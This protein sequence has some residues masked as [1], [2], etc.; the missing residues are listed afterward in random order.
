MSSICLR[1]INLYKIHGRY[2]LSITLNEGLNVIHGKN[3]AGKSTLIHIIANIVNCDFVRFAYLNFE[4]IEAIYTNGVEVLVTKEKREDDTYVVI[5]VSDGKSIYFSFNDAANALKEMDEER[6]SGD[7]KPSLIH[8]IHSFVK[9]YGLNYTTSSYFPAFRTM[10]E[11][12]GS[13]PES[14]F[15][16]RNYRSVYVQNKI[17][18]FARGLFGKFLPNINYPSP[19]EIEERIKEEIRRAQMGIARYEGRIFSESFVRVFS[20]LINRRTTE[21]SIPQELLS[22]IEGLVKTHD[23]NAK[24]NYYEEYSKIYDEIRLLINRNPRG[25]VESSVAGALTVYRDAL[26]ERQSYQE[27]AFYS[28]DKYF[29]SVNSFLEDKEVCY[30]FDLERRSPRVG[31][32]FPDD[33]WSSIRVMSSGERQLLTMLY[34]ASKMSEDSIV[35]I[36]E[37]EISLHIDWQED[38]LKKMLSQLSGRQ[39]IVCTHSPSIATGYEDCMILINPEFVSSRAKSD[40]CEFDEEDN[41]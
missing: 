23:D 34:A 41:I 27:Q 40:D 22:E 1:G 20:A 32:K 26:R 15:E 10:L 9:T 2:N 21:D 12:W 11:A 39:I 14:G 17:N 6:Y 25:E 31:L 16:R 4:K 33:T 7:T 36:D 3:G 35:L 24:I 37:P 13:Y 28:I 8:Y 29:N 5:S 38:L 19:I 18:K 30:Q